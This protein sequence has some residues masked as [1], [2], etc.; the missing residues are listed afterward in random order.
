MEGK[1]QGVWQGWCCSVGR[2]ASGRQGGRAA[3]GAGAREMSVCNL[4]QTRAQHVPWVSSLEAAQSW[5]HL[6]L[7]WKQGRA[8]EGLP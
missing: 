7:C 3:H 2:K 4:G 8:R 1:H 5:P 6:A